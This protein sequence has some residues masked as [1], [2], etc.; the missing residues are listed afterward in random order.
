[1]RSSAGGATVVVGSASVVAGSAS[2]ATGASV[3]T[4][5]VGSVAAG[6]A[7]VVAPGSALVASGSAPGS[8]SSLHAAAT[9]ATATPITSAR[10]VAVFRTSDP[11][12]GAPTLDGPVA[13]EP[14]RTAR[15]YYTV[16]AVTE[17]IFT[18]PP[19]RAEAMYA[20]MVAST[21]GSGRVVVDGAFGAEAGGAG[22]Q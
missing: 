15:F 8:S 13:A 16:R 12:V 19:V 5:S 17:G 2:V 9:S 14:G 21:S 18:L 22:G 1:M 11:L 3:P 10:V 20:P 6:V 4:G 7:A